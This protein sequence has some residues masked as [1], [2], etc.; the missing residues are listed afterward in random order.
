MVKEQKKDAE[1][2]KLTNEEADNK[3]G[4]V[5]AQKQE[6]SASDMLNFL[7]KARKGEMIPPEIIIQYANYFQDDLTLDNMPRMQLINMCKYMNI[8]PYGSDAFLR[9]QLRHKIRTLK[10]D[11]QRILWEGIDSLTKMELREACQ[12]RGMRSTGLSKDSYKRSLQQWLDL[13]VNKS[14]PISLLIM[15]R[16]FFLRDEMTTVSADEDGSKSMAGL[17]DAISGLDKDV[18]NEVVLEIATSEEKKSNPD[19][20]KI[21]LEVLAQQNERIREEQQ[22][23]EVAAKKK[24]QDKEKEKE[25]QEAL[26]EDS[27]DK[28]TAESTTF[29]DGMDGTTKMKTF[30]EEKEDSS[31]DVKVQ[32]QK[33]PMRGHP[34]EESKPV[35]EEPEEEE[36]ELSPQEMDAISQLANPD[37]VN[38]ERQDLERLKAAMKTEE[39][40]PEGMV[41]VA[42]GEKIFTDERIAHE[43]QGTAA[44]EQAPSPTLSTS[45]ADAETHMREAE[46]VSRTGVISETQTLGEA[47]VEVQE[48]KLEEPVVGNE[49]LEKAINRL[50]SKVESMVEKIETQLTDVEIKIGDK[51]HFLDKD[52]D[53]MVSREEMAL[54]LQQVLKRELTFDEAL[55][56][57]TT[58]DADNDGVLTVAEFISWIDSNQLVNLVEEGRDT[59]I[60]S[61]LAK[62]HQKQDDETSKSESNEKNN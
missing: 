9:F 10:E 33:A 19:V 31:G 29:D 22:E 27:T 39:E 12:E 3:D 50:K 14:V 57:A 52:M 30:E 62:Y 4:K 55:S 56:I 37:P 20:M 7:E 8:P 40:E 41:Q 51:L 13:S 28:I 25:K 53:G 18:V 23:R 6:E 5:I 44:S 59:D 35:E 2:R 42:E 16:T 17:A 34:K 43:I 1:R 48:R 21:K 38:K 32:E 54:C 36:A 26:Q 45:S 47:V 24:E 58:M 15:S 46:S 60:D 11:D 49:G 61:I